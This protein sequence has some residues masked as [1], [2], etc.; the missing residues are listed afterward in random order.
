VLLHGPDGNDDAV[1]AFEVGLNLWARRRCGD[2]WS[3]ILRA[4]A[5]KSTRRRGH[6]GGRFWQAAVFSARAL[7]RALIFGRWADLTANDLNRLRHFKSIIIEESFGAAQKILEKV[8]LFGV[9]FDLYRDGESHFTIPENGFNRICRDREDYDDLDSFG[10]DL[11]NQ[12][13]Q[14]LKDVTHFH[15]HHD[16]RSDSIISCAP[17]FISDQNNW[18]RQTLYAMYRKIIAI[19]KFDRVI[20]LSNALGIIAYA[21]SFQTICVHRCLP[22][23]R[24]NNANVVD[25]AEIF[26]G[27]VG[28]EPTDNRSFS[29]T[30]H[31]ILGVNNIPFY[32]SDYLEKSVEMTLEVAKRKLADLQWFISLSIASGIAGLAGYLRFIDPTQD[33]AL[34]DL[35]VQFRFP[36]FTF[37]I[38]VFGLITYYFQIVTPFKLPWAA[39]FYRLLQSMPRSVTTFILALITFGSLSFSIYWFGLR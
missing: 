28:E 34:R 19:R 20:E 38:L 30:E 11:V 35:L 24:P 10:L 37:S 36:I 9:K 3:G 33:N 6:Q 21:R 31:E 8:S 39:N 16:K 12:C 2:S 32:A 17:F 26:S 14:F 23:D 27:T 1:G 22:D 29:S 15:Q 13:F 5:R 4:G 25:A 18:R 7:A